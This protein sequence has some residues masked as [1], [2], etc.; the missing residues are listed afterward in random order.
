MHTHPSQSQRQQQQIP[1]ISP[2]ALVTK[3]T[4]AGAHSSIGWRLESPGMTQT[5]NLVQFIEKRNLLPKDQRKIN[6]VEQAA[7][8]F[9]LF[10]G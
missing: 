4:L 5:E 6:V 3:Q 10:P 7:L 8:R 9:W 1:T 2:V